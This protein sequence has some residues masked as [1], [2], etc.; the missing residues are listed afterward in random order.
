MTLNSFVLISIRKPRLEFLPR[1]TNATNGSDFKS[2]LPKYHLSSTRIWRVRGFTKMSFATAAPAVEHRELRETNRG[3]FQ[4][5]AAHE[6]C[7]RVSG[8]SDETNDAAM[9]DA[10]F[11]LP[12]L[13]LSI[14][15]LRTPVPWR[16]LN[17]VV[18]CTPCREH[19]C[20]HDDGRDD[21]ASRAKRDPSSPLPCTR[22]Y[23]SCFS[24]DRER[25]SN[26]FRKM[27]FPWSAPGLR[28]FKLRN[29]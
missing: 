6:V 7:H 11:E 1:T 19:L 4:E 21:H 24:T 28:R 16:L 22:K 23:F 8:L 3:C 9:V 17:L 15:E 5:E 12:R 10:D 27:S 18:P 14:L 25:F 20:Q 13:E 26:E 29:R 2:E